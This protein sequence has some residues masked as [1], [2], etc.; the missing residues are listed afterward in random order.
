MTTTVAIVDVRKNNYYVGSLLMAANLLCVPLVSRPGYTAT[1]RT[2]RRVSAGQPLQKS[3]TE[4]NREK[5][6]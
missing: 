2:V 4:A 5:S 1:I 6:L 3:V